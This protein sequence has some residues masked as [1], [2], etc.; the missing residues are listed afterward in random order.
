M[1]PENLLCN[2]PETVKLADFGL[3]REIRSQP[4]YTDYVST[5]WYR[6]PEV[7]LRSTNYNSPVDLFAVG[8]I[9]AELYTFRP[10]FPGSSEIDMVFKICSV[11]GTPSKSDWSEGYQLAAAMNF[12][13]PQCSP[14]PLHTLI[15]NANHEGIQLILDLISWNPKHRPTARE[16]LKRPYFKIIQAFKEFVHSETN[17]GDKL[18]DSSQCL[19][20]MS[21]RKQK[22]LSHN[23]QDIEELPPIQQTVVDLLN[24]H[25]IETN[26]DKFPNN[27]DH[28]NVQK[29]VEK[30][31]SKSNNDLSGRE[32][33]NTDMQ[34]NKETVLRL[35]DPLPNLVPTLNETVEISE[36][37]H[38]FIGNKIHA[39]S[40]TNDTISKTHQDIDLS[41]ETNP[42]LT[43]SFQYPKSG[44]S[45]LKTKKPGSRFCPALETDGFL[46]DLDPQHSDSKPPL[47]KIIGTD[48]H[49]DDNSCRRHSQKNTNSLNKIFLSTS[50]FIRQYQ[51]PPTFLNDRNLTKEVKQQNGPWFTNRVTRKRDSLDIDRFLD[52]PIVSNAKFGSIPSAAS[53]YK[54]KARYFPGP[55][56]N[57]LK[58]SQNTILIVDK[59]IQHPTD[60]YKENHPSIQIYL[61]HPVHSHISNTRNMHN[62]LGNLSNKVNVSH[63]L[64]ITQN[65]VRHLSDTE[66]FSWSANNYNTQVDDKSLTKNICKT[67]Q[68][69]EKGYLAK[70][71]D[72]DMDNK[73]GQQVD[74]FRS[75]M[76]VY[77]VGFLS[78]NKSGYFHPS[79]KAPTYF[80][81]NP[82]SRTDWAAKYLKS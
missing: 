75:H 13:F 82:S 28:F 38:R 49:R 46:G 73:T 69:T 52:P 64:P 30:S 10:L 61:D 12:K 16:A 53:F 34:G 54:S 74:R 8:C 48:K 14:V 80:H 31:T 6:A 1:K 59:S 22:L 55:V 36:L 23:L 4:P 27:H 76:G 43:G 77:G 67:T 62:S 37:H 35:E 79:T 33:L 56:N 25:Q 3:A 7:L 41:D 57:N 18:Q 51:P 78:G 5:R 58:E 65:A 66:L 47:K 63:G 29:K 39:F 42:F 32:Y 40:N 15:P 71:S 70:T 24:S 50:K 17:D 72:L 19:E 45:V 21:A 20:K 11:L 44:S 2:G 60:S 26:S 9:M 81:S 68:N